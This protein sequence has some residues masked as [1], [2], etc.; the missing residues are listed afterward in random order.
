MTPHFPEK[1]SRHSQ[2][3]WAFGAWE[4]K[5]EEEEEEEERHI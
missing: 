1:E 2:E 3:C 5:E 4:L